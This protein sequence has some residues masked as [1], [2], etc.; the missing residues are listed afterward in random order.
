MGSNDRRK[1][2]SD[3]HS[4]KEDALDDNHKRKT[5][6]ERHQHKISMLHRTYEKM[7]NP[8]IENKRT[9]KTRMERHQDQEE[10]DDD[11]IHID[12]HDQTK[13]YIPARKLNKQEMKKLKKEERLQQKEIEKDENKNVFFKLKYI[14][15]SVG[16]VFVLALIA[17]TTILYGG[18]LF[19][20][21]DRLMITPP[22][23]VE[24]EDGEILWYL[25]DEYR[26]PVSLEEMPD[27][28]KD[29][30][31]AVEDKRFYSHSGVDV[32]SIFRALYKDIIARSKVE[33]A[34]T[35]TQQLAKNLFLTNDKSWLRKTKEAMIA[36]YLERE[37]TKDEILEM[38]LNVI[39]FGQGQYGVEAAS[40]KFFYKSVEDLTL[41][42]A[43]LLAGIVNA[44]NG[45]SPIEHPDKAK[46]RRN[47]V[48]DRMVADEVIT[49]EAAEEA[50]NKEITLNIS[51]RKN[52]PAYHTI[53]DMAIKEAKDLYNITDE[54][55]KKNR[56]RIVTSL[57]ETIQ[58]IAYEQFQYDAYF[59]GNN[60]DEVEGA[61]VMMKEETGEIVAAVG[62]RRFQF[63]DYNRVNR[64]VGQPGST[65]KPIAVYA[66][67][68]ET[69]NYDPYT[70]LPDELQE[71][72]GQPVRNYNNEYDGTVSL[73]NALKYS[74]NTSAVWLL[75]NIGVKNGRKYLDKMHFDVGDDN[76]RR[77]ALG[78]LNENVSPIDMMQSF[79]PFIHSG[80][81]IDSYV[82]K[83]I[84]NQKGDI[85][86]SANPETVEVFSPQVAWNMTEMLR[87]V[88]TEGTAN[89][90]YY[91]YELAGKTGTTQH[92]NGEGQSKDAW[93][94]GYTP[95]Y[96]SALWMGYGEV[97]EEN[98]L[99]GGSAYPTELTKKILTEVANQKSVTETFIKPEKV[100]AL[101]EPIDLPTIDSLSSSF[102]FGGFK[103]LKAE[104]E[105]EGAK[106]ARIIYRI[107]E[108]GKNGEE[109]K[110]IGEVTEGASSFE[111]DEFLLFQTKEYYVVP[112]DPL[113]EIVGEPSNKV[114]VSF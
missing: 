30:F 39:Y 96:V 49:A 5:R 16:I 99:T 98:Y 33:G 41:E 109:D 27:H 34:S 59:P 14:I 87:N 88:V 24:T 46:S 95:D 70:A 81:M 60:M 7:M 6:S 78:D 31:I 69:G 106:D 45:Y 36:L 65:M 71:W 111:I 76:A 61:F 25:Y 56:Y 101:A 66:P 103:I 68:L 21:Q 9:L 74:K 110:K 75:D 51:Q 77:L 20:D 72:E 105:W 104:L 13:K 97:T 26:L 8:L 94:V 64:P 93:F 67:A 62:G 52:N 63:G 54:E 108:V 42:E 82:I 84:Y 38:Y 28:V 44:P 79:R 23:T 43:A 3:R 85:V 15:L 18:K 92:P 55:L 11:G 102:V 83:E 29:A 89:V 112:Y 19:V 86:G 2:R 48:L 53:V 90:G 58:Q 47:I 91:P 113:G 12:D 37:F 100:V 17:Y 107:Y 10:L 1:R 73:Y 22:T 35:I 50:K 40:N 32:R 114:E 4:N 80:E 57:D